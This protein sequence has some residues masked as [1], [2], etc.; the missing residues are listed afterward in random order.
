MKQGLKY[1]TL[2]ALGAFCLCAASAVALDLQGRNIFLNNTPSR[3]PQI[4]PAPDVGLVTVSPS[5]DGNFRIE[6]RANGVKTLFIIDTGAN[7]VSFTYEDA[8]R[9][10]IDVAKLDFSGRAETPNGIVEAA[11]TSLESLSLYGHRMKNVEAVVIKGDMPGA[12][13]GMSYL[14]RLKE[15]RLQGGKLVLRP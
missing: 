8:R 11:F 7:F 3:T 10:G 12:L 15:L 4:A 6:G 5:A 2:A 1:K 13:L 9:V 14:S